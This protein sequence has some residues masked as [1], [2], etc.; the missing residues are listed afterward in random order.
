MGKSLA[1]Q[2]DRE[3]A[4]CETGRPP[5]LVDEGVLM[6]LARINCTYAEM[7]AVLQVSVDTLERR[8]AA[9]I[10]EHRANGKSSLRRAQWSAALG[11]K[12]EK[13]NVVRAPNPTMLIWLGKQEL[14]QKDKSTSE[15]TGPG[16]TPL[17][18]KTI[19]VILVGAKP[20]DVLA[21]LTEV[22]QLLP[23]GHDD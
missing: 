16:G 8:F 23:G 10:E 9:F 20:R 6:R 13:G 17:A 12:D 3:D 18:P 5:A 15:Q 14:D 1:P 2:M 4:P 11:V 21:G 19:N 22:R 7:A